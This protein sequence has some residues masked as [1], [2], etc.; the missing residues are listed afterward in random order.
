MGS[1]AVFVEEEALP[2]SE[3]EA[4]VADGDGEGILSEHGADV[5]GHVIGAFG[6]VR[7]AGVAIGSEAGEEGLE[8][9]PD[10][11]IGVFAEDERGACVVEE[12]GGEAAI[13][14]GCGDEAVDGIGDFEGAAAAGVDDEVVLMEMGIHI[15]SMHVMH[16][17][18]TCV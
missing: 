15:T 9:V 4:G 16:C 13:D 5:G 1:S 11:G 12:D 6:V 3:V 10:G 14:A 7:V 17:T 18:S 8:V 2:G